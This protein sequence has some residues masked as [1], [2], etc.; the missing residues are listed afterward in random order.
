MMTELELFVLRIPEFKN[1]TS[2]QLIDYLAFYLQQ[3]NSNEVFTAAQIKICFDELSLTPYSNISSYLSRNTGKSGKYIKR[4]SGYVLNRV[5]K[6]H[7]AAEVKEILELPISSELIDLSLFDGTPY[8]LKTIA[9]EMI[10]SY[11]SG[12]YN[13]TLVLMRKLVETLI[14]EC[15]ERYGIEDVIKD[16]NENF[17]YLSDLIPRYLESAKWNSSRNINSCLKIVKKYGDL[18]AHNRR[19]LAKKTDIDGFKFELR[20]ALQE[21]ILTIDY[22]NWEKDKS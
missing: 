13:A 20:Q 19:F 9:K 2:G 5:I 11:D 7:I 4:K 12:F 10:H 3:I 15:F 22:S 17:F 16:A 8:Y 1:K 18:S 21:I 14:I 6:E